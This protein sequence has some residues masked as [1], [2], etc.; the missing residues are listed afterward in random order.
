MRCDQCQFYS[1]KHSE[2]REQ[3]PSTRQGMPDG[4]F[5]R[6]P[7]DSWC[8]RFR[9]DGTLKAYRDEI[10]MY[11]RPE[12]VEQYGAEVS[13]RQCERGI[14]AIAERKSR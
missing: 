9:P 1:H 14:N 13:A 4:G 11:R 3:S 6:I 2:C 7:A 10:E 5:P 8:G 12:Y